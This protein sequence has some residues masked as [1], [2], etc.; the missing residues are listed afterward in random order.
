MSQ[1]LRQLFSVLWRQKPGNASRQT[2]V[3]LS[4]QRPP[5]NDCYAWR[6]HWK[7][8]KQPWRTEPEIDPQRQ[9]E[10]NQCRAITPN[11]EKGIY[12]FKGMKLS[13]ADVEWLLATHE[14][15]RGPV[16][17]SD[18]SQREREGLDLRGAY[19]RSIDLNHLPLA[20]VQCGLA[21][22][23]WWDANEEQ[24]EDAGAHLQEAN[25]D[26]AHLEGA[27]LRWTHLEGA[28]LYGAYLQESRLRAAKLSGAILQRAHLEGASLVRTH[29]GGQ[30]TPKYLPPA[31]I[32]AAFFDMMTNLDRIIL[33]DE[34]HGVI[35]LADISWGD[36]NL[37]VVDWSPIR[38]LGDENV[39]R[40]SRLPDG[41]KKNASR[42]LREYQAAVR[43]NRQLSIALQ[44]QGINEDASRFAY[45][46]QVLQRKV[47]Q[48]QMLQVNLKLR[49]RIQALGTWLFSW[50]LFLLAGYGYK[51]GRSFLAYL[52]VIVTFMA[53]YLLLDPHLVWYEAV[54]VSMTAFHGRGFSPSAFSPGDPLS[55]ASAI[56]AFVGLIIEVTFI[57]TLTQQFFG[58]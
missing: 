15:G 32:N 24:R 3:A 23:D 19:L 42:L 52:L 47:F 36:V 20:R 13:R 28:S 31:K 22:R 11:I 53:L 9:K 50:F 35:S 40:Q 46:A 5:L 30:T 56:E 7:A 27:N 33:G 44:T 51:L 8:Q 14:D 21:T 16:N 48:F 6:A 4:L 58:K 26:W 2:Q 57:A 1:R 45:R 38:V 49:R 37:A 55:I 34:Q 10:L 17:W 18:E 41:G 25:L 43:A 29:L 54:V 12:P 39:A